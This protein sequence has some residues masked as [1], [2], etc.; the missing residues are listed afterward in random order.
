MVIAGYAWFTL[1]FFN[2]PWLATVDQNYE[3]IDNDGQPV[4]SN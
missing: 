1:P 4:K 2:L 3:F